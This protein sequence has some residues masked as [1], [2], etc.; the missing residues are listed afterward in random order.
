M[1]KAT[2]QYH[3]C[4][5]VHAFERGASAENFEVLARPYPCCCKSKQ[6]LLGQIQPTH[7]KANKVATNELTTHYYI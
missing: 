3:S 4:N 6:Q 7:K 5:V 1:T 2:E